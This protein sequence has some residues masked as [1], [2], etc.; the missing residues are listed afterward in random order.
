MSLIVRSKIKSV[1]KGM[2]VSGDFYNALDKKVEEVLRD[3]AK[4]AKDNGR[5]TIRP[6]DL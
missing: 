3:A 5:A 4:R 1:I 6:C 2:R